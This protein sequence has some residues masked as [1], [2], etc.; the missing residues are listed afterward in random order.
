MTKTTM[1]TSTAC[2][3]RDETTCSFLNHSIQCH[4]PSQF[5]TAVLAKTRSSMAK[6]KVF[7]FCQFHEVEGTSEKQQQYASGKTNIMFCV[8]V[9][10]MFWAPNLFVH[11]RLRRKCPYSSK[12][13]HEHALQRIPGEMGEILNCYT[14]SNFPLK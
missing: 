6:E 8:T 14:S 12:I 1:T 13:M 2:L 10:N 7:F 4:V 11:V 9:T 5:V 3:K